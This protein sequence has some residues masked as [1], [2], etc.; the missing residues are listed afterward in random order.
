[1][2]SVTKLVVGCRVVG[3]EE[4]GQCC[5]GGDA[6]SWEIVE[7]GRWGPRGTLVSHSL[8]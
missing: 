7:P 6:L 4:P 8:S 3:R 2:V 5:P 1:V